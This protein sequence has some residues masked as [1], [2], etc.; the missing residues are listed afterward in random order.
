MASP[1]EPTTPLRCFTG[2]FIAG[3]LGILLYRL[4]QAVAY[5]FATH[6]LHSHSQIAQS[7]STAVR[8]LVVGLCTMATG[9][10]SI[11]ALGLLGLGIQIL[12]QSKSIVPS[13]SQD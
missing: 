8:T 13:D 7:L 11:A 9:V 2:A 1:S 12:W 10:F 5:S 4:T 3:S 6:P